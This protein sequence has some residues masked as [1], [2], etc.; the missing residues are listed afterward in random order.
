MASPK[1]LPEFVLFGASMT[2]WSFDEK[3]QGIGWFLRTRYDGKVKVLNEGQA[4]YTSTR[5]QSDFARIIDRAT[6][7]SA[8]Q[9]LLFT[10]FIGANDA[11]FIG[12]KEFVP[13]P[14]FCGNIRAYVETILTE[15]AMGDTK[16]VLIA[17][18]PINGPEARLHG[19]ETE[20]NIRDINARNREQQR[21]RTYMSKKRYADGVMGIAREYEETG[22]VLGVD[23]WKGLVEQK[24]KEDGKGKWEDMEESGLWPGSGLIGAG[25]F[26]KEWFTD[27]L[28]LDKKGYGV[29]NRMLMEGVLEKWPEL[30]PEKL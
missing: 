27:G 14:T 4:G 8:P 23:F 24:I 28:H 6:S 11:C 25:Q 1:Q 12:A 10:I 26:G 13:F 22:R 9:T 2:E 17:P 15:D 21:Y 19:K 20:E 16:I 5:L 7:P 29:L 3:T 30:A 18:P